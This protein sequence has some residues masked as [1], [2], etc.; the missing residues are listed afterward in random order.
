MSST[1][2]VHPPDRRVL[3]DGKSAVPAE[4]HAA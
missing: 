2:I 4:L 3:V 1:E